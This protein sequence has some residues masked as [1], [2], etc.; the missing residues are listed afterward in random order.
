MPSSDSAPARHSFWRA[1]DL[2]ASGL[3]WAT[4]SQWRGLCESVKG[5]DGFLQKQVW[6]QA[7]RS[8]GQGLGE[9][10]DNFHCLKE[11]SGGD[12]L[13]IRPQFMLLAPLANVSRSLQI[14]PQHP[15]S[16]PNPTPR[17]QPPTPTTLSGLPRPRQ[18]FKARVEEASDI[19]SFSGGAKASLVP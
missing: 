19:I 13:R 5:N 6:S 10:A 12:G 7:H 1:G 15:Q 14:S 9:G 2:A 8:V 11:G 18:M 17:C 16:S 3:E 4:L